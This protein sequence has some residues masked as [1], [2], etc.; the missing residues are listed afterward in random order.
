MRAKIG[1]WSALTSTS[2]LKSRSR[3]FLSFGLQKMRPR[4]V[5]PRWRVGGRQNEARIEQSNP[6][7]AT[8]VDREHVVK[9]EDGLL[10]AGWAGSGERECV[11]VFVL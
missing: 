11:C 5:S 8:Y 1:A 2:I 6:H 4:M 3:G 7:S 10:P 9:V